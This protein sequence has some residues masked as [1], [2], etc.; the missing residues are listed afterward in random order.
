MLPVDHDAVSVI[1]R[2]LQRPDEM[3]VPICGCVRRLN[4]RKVDRELVYNDGLT[5]KQWALNSAVECH[6]HTVEVVG[7]NPTAPTILSSCRTAVYEYLSFFVGRIP[8]RR[9]PDA[10]SLSGPRCG[11]CRQQLLHIFPLCCQCFVEVSVGVECGHLRLAVTEQGLR[12]GNVLR[13]LVCP[14]A[15]AMTETVPTKTLTLCH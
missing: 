13:H 12:N 3:R 5:A 15:Q 14:R 11:L 9:Q 7:S 8:A 2:F 1:P 10:R 6:P 4:E